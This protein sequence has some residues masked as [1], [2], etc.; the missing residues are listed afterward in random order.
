MENVESD[1]MMMHELRWIRMD[2]EGNGRVLSEVLSQHL[3][4]GTV[5]KHEF[6]SDHLRVEVQTFTWW[7]VHLLRLGVVRWVQYELF[8]MDVRWR[9]LASQSRYP[10][11]FACGFVWVWNLV[12]DS[13]GGTYT[14]GVWEQGAEEN[15]WTER[16][17]SDRRMERTT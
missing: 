3:P 2:L 17:W 8:E 10:Y 4:V 1:N 16:R 12:S 15:I 5:E 11:K 7:T 13:K 6:R 9:W 14:E